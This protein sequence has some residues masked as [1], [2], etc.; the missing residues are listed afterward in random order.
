MPR[1]N[2][3]SLADETYIDIVAYLLNLNKF[4]LGTRDLTISTLDS[5]RLEVQD[6]P[7][8][9]PSGALVEVVGCL[10]RDVLG[11]WTLAESGEPQR[12]GHVLTARRRKR[13]N[14]R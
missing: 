4:P 2:P 14:L 1:R 9:V 6:G 12:T 5:I 11:N 8:P 10:T 7:Q 13:W 3:E